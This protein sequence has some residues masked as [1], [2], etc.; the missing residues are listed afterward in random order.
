[1]SYLLGAAFVAILIRFRRSCRRCLDSILSA[2]GY[3]S[4][5][6]GSKTCLGI[7]GVKLLTGKKSC[8]FATVAT[9]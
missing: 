6:E 9:T 5:C 3:L 8:G 1:M 4:Y 2:D 7:E